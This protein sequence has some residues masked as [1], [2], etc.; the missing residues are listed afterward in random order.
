MLEIEQ[1]EEILKMKQ[2]KRQYY[3]RREQDKEK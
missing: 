1:E 2:F 3:E